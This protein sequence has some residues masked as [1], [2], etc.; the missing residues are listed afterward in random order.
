MGGKRRV[1]S[2]RVFPYNSAPP[3]LATL[4]LLRLPAASGIQQDPDTTIQDFA[5]LET[6]TRPL[7]LEAAHCEETET[8]LQNARK[9][10]PAPTNTSPLFFHTETLVPNPRWLKGGEQL[11]INDESRAHSHVSLTAGLVYGG[12]DA[13]GSVF[14]SVSVCRVL[15]N[16]L[17]PVGTETRGPAWLAG[18]AGPVPGGGR[19]Y[20]CLRQS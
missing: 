5:R 4:R 7:F 2:R 1:Q 16:R 3:P 6:T 8:F 12:K 18:Q 19:I 17:Q 15:G 11:G 9:T 10:S 20:L 14:L 13:R